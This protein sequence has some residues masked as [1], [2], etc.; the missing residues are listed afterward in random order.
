M[1]IHPRTLTP[2]YQRA[3]YP[4]TRSIAALPP[5][6]SPQDD[7]ATLTPQQKGVCEWVS[8]G[9]GNAFVEAVAGS[10]KTHTL[11]AACG[12]MSGLVAYCVFNKKNADEAKPKLAHLPNVTPGTFHSFGFSAWRL[13]MGQGS[14]VPQMQVDASLK[15]RR[16]LDECQVPQKFHAAVTKMVGLAKQSVCGKLWQVTDTEEWK[17]L[18]SHHDILLS[19]K[20]DDSPVAYSDPVAREYANTAWSVRHEITIAELIRLSAICI[21][22]SRRVGTSLI[23][24]DD[25]IYLPLVEDTPVRRYDWV[26]VDEAQDTNPARRLLATRMLKP[27]GRAVFVGDRNQAIY[28][29]TGADADAVDLIIRE[30]GCQSLSLTTTFR[31]SKT[32]TRLAQEYVPQIEAADSNAEGTIDYLSHDQLMLNNLPQPGSAILCRNTKPLVE[33]AFTLIKEGVGCHVEGRDIG[34]G[35]ERLATKWKTVTRV[36]DLLRKLEEY[37]YREIQK[38]SENGFQENSYAIDSLNDRI[39]CL[40]AVSDGC[41]TIDDILRKIERI[42]QDTDPSGARKTVTL[43]TIHKAKGREWETVYQ[44]GFDALLPSRH[45]R[46]PWQRDQERNLQYVTLTRT[47]R[48]TIFLTM[49]ERGERR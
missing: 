22:W 45:A 10:G 20:E 23:D 25:M 6:Y 46:Q 19:V 38:L 3:P 21:T 29:F 28:G 34:R 42:F 36:T 33:L 16:M 30:F 12:F 26:L 9:T 7:I 32:A 13:A 44:L 15:Q 2:R 24:F 39:D 8:S 41:L 5:R 31:C 47:K 35:L 18:I 11:R 1:A 14:G 40:I 49:Q 48:D 37:R 43:S 4:R 27:G 17:R